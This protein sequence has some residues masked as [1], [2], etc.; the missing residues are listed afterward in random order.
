[1]EYGIKLAE[2]F[3][4]SVTL[5]NSYEM[6]QKG[7]MIISMRTPLRDKAKERMHEVLN[8]AQE[9]SSK[10]IFHSLILE[11]RPAFEIVQT[12]KVDAY[13]LIVMGTKGANG[14]EEIFIGSVANEVITNTKIPVIVI[15]SEYEYNT[16]ETVVFPMSDDLIADANVILPLNAII[17][18]F[19]AALEIY[20]FGRTHEQVEDL[21]DNLDIIDDSIDYS[22]T[23]A[24]GIGSEDVNKRIQDFASSKKADLICLIR[25]KRN[26]WGKLF[27]NS[28]TSTQ[29]FHS[30]KP[31]LILHNE[32]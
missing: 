20:H 15:P 9:I 18:K 27:S 19:N 21:S 24:Y 29:T 4:S 8:I 16:T 5:L 28:V 23:Y 1:M 22:V 2:E 14:L 3:G 10:V 32:S 12:A 13:D 7:G 17:K 26:L 11:G 6:H 31:L 25:K 30:K